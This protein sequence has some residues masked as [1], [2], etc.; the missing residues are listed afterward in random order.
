MGERIRIACNVKIVYEVE[1]PTRVY[2]AVFLVLFHLI[3]LPSNILAEI[4]LLSTP[5]IFY[6]LAFLYYLLILTI[7]T[8][9]TRKHPKKS[10]K[11]VLDI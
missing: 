6:A 2:S 11:S 4:S 9:L 8:L 10:P 5:Y 1:K 3:Y 7:F